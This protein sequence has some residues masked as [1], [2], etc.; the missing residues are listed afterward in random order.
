MRYLLYFLIMILIAPCAAKSKRHK[1]APA[2]K[3]PLPY[4]TKEDGLKICK[5]DPANYRQAKLN[6]CRIVNLPSEKT[7]FVYWLPPDFKNLPDRLMMVALHG[8]NGSAYKTILDLLDTARLENF[9][10]IS[11]QWGWPKSSLTKTSKKSK[12]SSTERLFSDIRQS[13][14]QN[15][16][17]EAD[18]VNESHDSLDYFDYLGYETVYKAAEHALSY[19][20]ESEYGDLKSSALYCPGRAAT[21]CPALALLDTKKQTGLYKLF[22]SAYGY[23]EGTVM[24]ELNNPL[25]GDL[26]L[27]L[28]NFYLFAGVRD[29]TAVDN[30]HQA[31]RKIMELGGRIDAVRLAPERYN[32]FEADP[33]YQREAIFFWKRN[34]K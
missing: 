17:P 31:K 1:V 9:A 26:P 30:L 6:G 34:V 15:T 18:L 19:L 20:M 2:P 16:D 27:S 12:K 23:E 13:E 7:F 14:K 28:K 3:V 5:G 32:G 4:E 29:S 24:P 11:L 10:L 33:K 8:A 21:I 25:H 22:I